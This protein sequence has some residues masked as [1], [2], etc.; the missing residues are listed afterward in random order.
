MKPKVTIT[1]ALGIWLA[2][3]LVAGT[4]LTRIP[5]GEPDGF[6]GTGF[7]FAQVYWDLRPE[8]GQMIDYPNI[9]ALVLNIAA[10]F[11]V[12]AAVIYLSWLI[13]VVSRRFRR[14]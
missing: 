1:G 7:P 10:V 9:F 12:G 5:W 11:A 6:H 13:V 4:W 2:V 14:E 8:T 3:S